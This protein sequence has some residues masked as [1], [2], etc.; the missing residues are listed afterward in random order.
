MHTNPYKIIEESTPRRQDI[1]N[2]IHNNKGARGYVWPEH[3]SFHN[4]STLMLTPSLY[5]FFFHI[6]LEESCT[7]ASCF[8]YFLWLVSCGCIAQ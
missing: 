4:V 7:D 3:I 8:V 2:N 1:H 6:H 5:E